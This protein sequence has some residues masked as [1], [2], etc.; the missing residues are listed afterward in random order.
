MRPQ[1]PNVDDTLRLEQPTATE[2][3][4]ELADLRVNAGIDIQIRIKGHSMQ[5]SKILQFK[6][7]DFS[8]FVKGSSYN[9]GLTV[10]HQ[11]S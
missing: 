4:G 8:N 10:V 11:T 3:A 7:W 6:L 9:Q 5:N 1:R 2:K